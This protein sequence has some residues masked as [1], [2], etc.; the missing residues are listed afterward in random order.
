LNGLYGA[1][2]KSEWNNYKI[3]KGWKDAS[4]LTLKD[5][6][7]IM[8]DGPKPKF[9]AKKATKEEKKTPAKK[10]TAADKTAVKK[11]PVKKA[12]VKKTTPKKKS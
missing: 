8:K 1:Y 10:A 9:W 5:C 2:I 11:T 7:E 12:A 6:L 3:P 4:D